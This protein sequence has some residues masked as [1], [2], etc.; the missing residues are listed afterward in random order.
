VPTVLGELLS[1]KDAAESQRVM[2]AMLKT[3]KLDIKKLQTAAA[4]K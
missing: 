2:K 1:S 4:G 3:V